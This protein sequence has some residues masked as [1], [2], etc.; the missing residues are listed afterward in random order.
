MEKGRIHKV[1]IL[2]SFLMVLLLLVVNI[3]LWSDFDAKDS[4]EEKYLKRSENIRSELGKEMFTTEKLN[5]QIAVKNL[6][7]SVFN[8]D[9][10]IKANDVQSS[11]DGESI[12]IKTRI[13]NLE[14]EIIELSN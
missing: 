1:W 6:R 13:S 10:D 3:L 8:D 5:S 4:A 7:Q 11:A 14:K 9:F 12:E 2:V